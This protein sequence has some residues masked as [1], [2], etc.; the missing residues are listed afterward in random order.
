MWKLIDENTPKDR[1]ILVYAPPYEDLKELYSVCR[2]HEDAGFCI[3]ELREPTLW[4]EIPK[5]E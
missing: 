4:C 3:D 2:W 5:V 1:D